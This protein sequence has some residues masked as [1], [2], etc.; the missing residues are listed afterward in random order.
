MRG[1]TAKYAIGADETGVKVAGEK[2]WAWTWQNKDAT[3]ITITDNRGQKSIVDTFKEI[4]TS[5]DGDDYLIIKLPE[6]KKND[7]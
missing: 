5:L 1:I 4:W 3:F 6:D 7:R 2:H